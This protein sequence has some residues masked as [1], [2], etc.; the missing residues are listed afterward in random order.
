M[1]HLEMQEETSAKSY[2]RLVAM[3]VPQLNK[4][5]S[6]GPGPSFVPAPAS[7]TPAL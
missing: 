3:H 2:G 6:P 5:H 1:F 4:H 7:H